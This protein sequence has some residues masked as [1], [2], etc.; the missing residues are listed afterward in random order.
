M[1][2]ATIGIM[3][4]L[5]TIAAIIS[6]NPMT[7][8]TMIAPLVSISVWESLAILSHILPPI[9]GA[10]LTIILWIHRRLS[11][12]EKEQEQLGKSVFGNERDALNEG[13]IRE[14]REMS[15]QLE[16]MQTCIEQIREQ[17]RR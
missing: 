15:E 12:I 6:G 7:G 14:V 5:A 3:I 13:V 2:E 11:Y 8:A 10:V 1:K 9:V 16:E 4:G 17:D